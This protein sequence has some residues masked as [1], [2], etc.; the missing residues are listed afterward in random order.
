MKKQLFIALGLLASGS[1]YSVDSTHVSM[2]LEEAKKAAN[3]QKCRYK[4]MKATIKEIRVCWHQHSKKHGQL[5][6]MAQEF[7]G[8]PKQAEAGEVAVRE[9]HAILERCMALEKKYA[10][11]FGSNV[12]QVGLLDPLPMTTEATAKK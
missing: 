11:E 5:V 6:A 1:M 10:K 9:Y 3:Q 7:T 2:N 12:N 8:L 4:T